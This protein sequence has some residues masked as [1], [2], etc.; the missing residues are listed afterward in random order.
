MRTEDKVQNKQF[1]KLK[2]AKKTIKKNE[3]K[4]TKKLTTHQIRS[5]SNNKT[6]NQTYRTLQKKKKEINRH[7]HAVEDVPYGHKI[8]RIVTH[9]R[10]SSSP[11]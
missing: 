2:E 1:E 3:E 4:K 10:I 11:N 6:K 7:S 8:K 9:K 5:S